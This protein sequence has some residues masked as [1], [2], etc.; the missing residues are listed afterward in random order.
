MHKM[1]CVVTGGVLKEYLKELENEPVDL[2]GE[3]ELSVE[4]KEDYL[5]FGWQKYEKRY[6]KV[7]YE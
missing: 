4:Q 7:D 2:I 3:G 1:R 5:L 6:K